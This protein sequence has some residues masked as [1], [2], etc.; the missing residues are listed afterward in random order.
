[1]PVE[2]LTFVVP[3]DPL[4]KGSTR[5]FVIAGRARTTSA[6]KGLKEWENRVVLFLPAARPYF[7]G[8]VSLRVHFRLSRPKSVRRQ[9]HITKPD[10]D[11]LARAIGDAL[12]GVCYRDDSQINE[13]HW[14]KDY[15]AFDAHSVITIKGNTDA[16]VQ[17]RRKNRPQQPGDDPAAPHPQ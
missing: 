10:L 6:T 12:T 2:T 14:R 16:P 1:M 13:A 11:K 4:P 7:H 8:A 5:A 17:G 15:A 3:G 9:E